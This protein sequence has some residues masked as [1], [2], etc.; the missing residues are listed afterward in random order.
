MVGSS[1]SST[2]GLP[3]QR[4]RQQH[5]DFLSALQLAH[6]PFVQRFFDAQPI[7]QNGGVGFGG[8]AAFFADDAFQLAQAHAVGVGEFIVRLGVENFAFLQRFPQR[9]DCP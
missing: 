9:S 1:S 6:F 8:V 4:L 2:C 5:A 7:Q 3:K